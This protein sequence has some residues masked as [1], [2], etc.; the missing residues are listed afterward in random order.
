MP[1]TVPDSLSRGV[2]SRSILPV[3]S[4]VL[5]VPPPEGKSVPVGEVGINPK[6]M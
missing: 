1:P 3:S 2:I 4:L 6:A 5:F